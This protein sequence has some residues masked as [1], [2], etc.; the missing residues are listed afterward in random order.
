MHPNVRAKILN[1]VLLFYSFLGVKSLKLDDIIVAG[2][3]AGYNY[4]AK[5]DLDIHLVV[6]YQNIPDSD[7]LKNL[8]DTKRFLWS[9]YYSIKIHHIPTEMYV[10]DASQPVDSNGIYSVLKGEWLKIPDPKDPKYNDAE[11]S[12]IFDATV[13]D[14][15]QVLKIP[16][17]N[18]INHLLSRIHALRSE[19]LAAGGEYSTKNVVYKMLRSKGYID[20]L[21]AQKQKLIDKKYSL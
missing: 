13:T 12:Q 6:N 21:L 16:S 17:I 20:K 4:T 14:I 8:F 5:S 10:Q 7:I 19:G 2:S 9:F 11:I 3:N 15:Q 18:H 1:E